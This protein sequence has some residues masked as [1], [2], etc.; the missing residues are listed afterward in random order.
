MEV[1]KLEQT[2]LFYSRKHS[3]YLQDPR[4]KRLQQIIVLELAIH[5]WCNGLPFSYVLAC[6]CYDALGE[7]KFDAPR[8]DKS[9]VKHPT[10]TAR[11]TSLPGLFQCMLF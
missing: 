11:G 8:M 6:L 3:E 4:L 9:D 1:F 2:P 7:I 5:L 10:S